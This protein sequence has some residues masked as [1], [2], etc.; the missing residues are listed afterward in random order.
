MADPSEL[1]DVTGLTLAELRRVPADQMAPALR[2]I[3]QQLD[4]GTEPVAGF[5]SAV[6]PSLTS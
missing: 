1:V 3:I 5:Q 6:D 4:D 2:R